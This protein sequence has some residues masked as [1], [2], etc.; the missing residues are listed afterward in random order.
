MILCTMTRRLICTSYYSQ[1]IM[2]IIFGSDRS[3]ATQK[4]S[5]QL[6]EQSVLVKNPGKSCCFI[7]ESSFLSSSSYTHKKSSERK[8]AHCEVLLTNA[9]NYS[10]LEPA[11][12]W[13]RNPKQKWKWTS[14]TLLMV[15]FETVETLAL[16][17][18]GS[19]SIPRVPTA[20]LARINS[21]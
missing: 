18:L 19:A 4:K 17:L 11:C 6:D 16:W 9:C 12:I 14:Q 21:S 13:E 7:V 15:A 8:G 1:F 20:V 5:S 2:F 3:A 10:M